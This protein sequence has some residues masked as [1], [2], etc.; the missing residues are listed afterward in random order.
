MLDQQVDHTLKALAAHL[1][2]HGQGGLEGGALGLKQR[3]DLGGGIC[4]G[5]EGLLERGETALRT[6][7]V[8]PGRLVV[9][10]DDEDPGTSPES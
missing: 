3:K 10:R 4:G 9:Q 2:G 7:S 8:R 6:V 5:H 1:G